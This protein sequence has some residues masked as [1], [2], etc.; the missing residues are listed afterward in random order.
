[1][2]ALRSSIS[3]LGDFKLMLFGNKGFDIPKWEIYPSLKPSSEV[4][5]R[6]SGSDYKHTTV[7]QTRR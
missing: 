7:Y 5:L 1:M 6:I 4:N 3:K 2:T